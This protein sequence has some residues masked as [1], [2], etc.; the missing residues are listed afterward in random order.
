M[1]T[2][3]VSAQWAALSSIQFMM[4]YASSCP[5]TSPAASNVRVAA[6]TS[7]R[8]S[9]MRNVGSVKPRRPDTQ[10]SRPQQREIAEGLGDGLGPLGP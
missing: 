10:R 6:S 5:S 7:A 2:A 4:T 1:L 3:T 8:M 9:L